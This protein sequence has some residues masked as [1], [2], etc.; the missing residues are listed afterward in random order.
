MPSKKSESADLFVHP[1]S[2]RTA[3]VYFPFLGWLLHY[4]RQDLLGDMLAGAIA[5]APDLQ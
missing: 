5:G 3:H 4:Q 1:H 2:Q